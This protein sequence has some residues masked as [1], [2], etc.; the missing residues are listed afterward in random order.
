VRQAGSVVHPEYLRFDFAYPNSITIEQINKIEQLVNEK[1]LEDIPVTIEHSTMQEAVDKGAVAFFGDKYNPDDVRVVSVADYSMELCGG[2][3]IDSTGEIGLL[4]ITEISAPS[5]GHKRITAV[6]GMGALKL[7]QE[8]FA[9]V[10]KLGSEFKVPREQ[11]VAAVDRLQEQLKLCQND[12][13]KLKEAYWRSNLVVWKEQ[14]GS[15]AD[16]PFL[17]LDMEGFSVEEL[18]DIAASLAEHRPGFYF[19]LSRVDGRAVFYCML[20]DSFAARLDLKKLAAWLKDNHN[21]RGGG[22]KLSL[23]GG[24]QKPEPAMLDAL[25]QWLGE[26]F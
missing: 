18:R 5:A 2:N 6:T 17:A 8:T 1:I 25:Q 23:Q 13:A 10:K 3:H 7:M 9:A 4:K 12:Y 21:L 16:M 20:S 24:G 22:S 11:V 19:L 26:Q 15:I 14:I